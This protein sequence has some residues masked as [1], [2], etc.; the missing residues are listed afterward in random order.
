MLNEATIM[1]QAKRRRD[2]IGS[3]VGTFVDVR[4]AAR[5]R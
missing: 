3:V 2:M 1:G 4:V 5:M